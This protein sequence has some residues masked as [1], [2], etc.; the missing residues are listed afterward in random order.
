MSKTKSRI[1]QMALVAFSALLVVL[2]LPLI[3]NIHDIEF[4][5]GR[6][7]EF[8]GAPSGGGMPPESPGW[9]LFTMILRVF[10]A[11]AFVVFLFQLIVNRSF[12][13]LFLVVILI[14]GAAILASEIFGWD[15]LIPPPPPADP[16][17]IIWEMV[18]E[19]DLNIQPVEREVEASNAQT[20]ILAIILSSI[21][22]IVGG[23]VVFKWLKARPEATDD[24]YDEIL[25]SITDAAQR[26][27]AGEDPRTVVLFCYQEMI[28]ILS[29]KGNIDASCLTP[30]EFE[31][32]LHDLGMSGESISQLTV[33]FEIVRYA[34]RVD[35]SFAARALTCLEAI[36]EVHTIDEH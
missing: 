15:E 9:Q 14:T 20:I 3:G 11:I 33:I 17:E 31:V 25:E 24:G 28:R 30:R 21:V 5:A 1:F 22:V 19:E 32:R 13:G 16:G 36:Q 26:I 23:I 18:P 2:I 10:F 6:D 27:R 7:T 4:Q 34:G 29:I 12:R 35:D 8:S